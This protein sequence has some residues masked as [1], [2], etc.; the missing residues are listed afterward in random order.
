MPEF[1]PPTDE[2]EF[3]KNFEQI[4]PLMNETEAYYES[5]RCLFCYDAPCTLACPTSI[6]VPLFIRQINSGNLTGAAKT[7]YNANYFGYACGQ[8]CPTEVLCEEVCVYNNQKIK[9]V[10]IGRLQA[11]AARHVVQN[12]KNL[13]PIKNAN[14]KRIAVIG[15]GP[16]GISCACELMKMGFSVDIFEKK[17][18]ASGLMISGVA[19][20][21]ITDKAV[22][23][24]MR[25][26]EDQFGYRV[27]YNTSIQSEEDMNRLENEYHA[28]FIGIG[29]GP[30]IE[31]EIPGEELENCVGAIEFIENL[32]LKRH[33]T[34]IG[35]KVIVLGGGNTAMDAASESARLGAETVLLCYR[36]SKE[37][38][39][40]Y[41]FEYDLAKS[42]G[43]SGVFNV[44]PL[45]I[46]G[47]TKV[48]GVKFARSKTVA[49]KVELMP[50]SEFV[51][52]CDMVIKATGQ[53]NFLDLLQRI[54]NIKLDKKGCILVNKDNGQTGNP[55]YFAGGDAANGGREVVNAAAEGKIA[56]QGIQQFIFGSET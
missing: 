48:E 7:I 45:E 51:E 3:E 20:Y 55:K 22:M 14:R 19:P 11:Y 40:A 9:P 34:K 43:T 2:L 32:R 10:E 37:E 52:S 38:M 8:V 53:S 4:K 28:I 23:D 24:E 35:K 13:F 49:G 46:L 6:D 33:R 36:R 27:Y 26:L 31:L 47:E 41:I 25:Y 1:L 18:Q 50:H 56:A 5:S 15:A 30:T 21:K 16:A 42:A 12:D 39:R 54:K 29:L 17:S 44:A